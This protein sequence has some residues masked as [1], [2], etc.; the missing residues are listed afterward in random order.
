[1][2]NSEQDP[3]ILLDIVEKQYLTPKK[4]S[5]WGRMYCPNF[6]LQKPVK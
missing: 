3:N 5:C 6:F 2:L 4:K 1:M